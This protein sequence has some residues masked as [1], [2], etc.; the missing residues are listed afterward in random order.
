[1]KFKELLEEAFS[2]GNVLLMPP[3]FADAILLLPLS[4][5]LSMVCPILN[6]EQLVPEI[7]PPVPGPRPQDDPKCASIGQSN[8]A[9]RGRQ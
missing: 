7:P 4:F 2:G 3:A 5:T 1:M 9:A 6:E 8:S